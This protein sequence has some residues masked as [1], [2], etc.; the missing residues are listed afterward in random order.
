MK[1]TEKKKQLDLAG[2]KLAFSTP[3]SAP[4]IFH[5]EK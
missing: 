2:H 3:P 5:L 1:L 4:L